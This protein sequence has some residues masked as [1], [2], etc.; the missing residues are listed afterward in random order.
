M[1]HKRIL[2]VVTAYMYKCC[3]V[4]SGGNFLA[5]IGTEETYLPLNLSYK[6]VGNLSLWEAWVSEQLFH[7]FQ[8]YQMA[9]S[10][11]SYT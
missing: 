3:H 2:L 5:Q 8:P 9:S 4:R 11:N 6:K 10:Q 1:Q 7:F